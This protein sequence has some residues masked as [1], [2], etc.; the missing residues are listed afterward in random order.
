MPSEI[1]NMLGLQKAI[2]NDLAL[3][4]LK[5]TQILFYTM[6]RMLYIAVMAIMMNFLTGPKQILNL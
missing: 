1:Q 3:A 5:S 2:V 6:P 4:I